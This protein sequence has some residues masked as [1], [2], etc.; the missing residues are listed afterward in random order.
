MRLL[1][2][3]GSPKAGSTALQNWLRANRAALDEQGIL[4]WRGDGAK[5]DPAGVLAN[6][7]APPKRP[8]LPHERLHFATRAEATAWSDRIWQDLARD[9][10]AARPALT[11]LSSEG[12][13]A[14]RKAQAVH[15]LLADLFDDIT[16]LVYVRDP[17]A[18]YVSALDQQIRTGVRLAKLPVPSGFHY[19]PV[20][21]VRNWRKLLGPERVIVRN[22]AR[23]GLAGGDLATDF[24]GQLGALAGHT[25]TAPEAVPRANESLC[26]AATLLLLG[27]NETFDRFAKGGDGGQ[28]RARAALIK[29]LRAAP[30]LAGMPKLRLSDPA[31][32][33]WVRHT[34]REAIAFYNDVFDPDQPPLPQAPEGTVIPDEDDQRAR[35]RGWIEAATDT[36]DLAAALRAAYA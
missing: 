29:R 34:H 15:A 21:T 6:R 18:H 19:P 17:A 32:A 3:I 28:I 4:A 10:R 12:L 16:V 7:F 22:F 30:E 27:M 33:D 20:E 36:V 14:V 2:H 23:E 11:V 25:V 24:L 8:L 35:L 26:A 1:L 13:F 9:V 31:H 5:G